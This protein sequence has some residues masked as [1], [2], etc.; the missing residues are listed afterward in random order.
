MKGPH[1]CEKETNTDHDLEALGWD[2]RSAAAFDDAGFDGSLEP[3]RVAI[4]HRRGYTVLVAG[5]EVE[6]DV[7]GKLRKAARLS[8]E[9]P[10]VGD[11]VAL[12]R[13]PGEDRAV[14]EAVLPRRSK[15][16]RKVAGFDVDEQ[17]V[18]ANV[19]LV[20]LVSALDQDLNVRRIE[21]YL[22]LTWDS[23]ARPVIVLTKADL[24]EDVPGAVAEVKAHAPDVPVHV[25][26]SVTLDG[27]D[28]LKSY[29]GQRRTIALLGSSGTGKSTLVNKLA[30]DDV[31]KVS[32]IRWDGKGRHTTTHRR[33]LPLSTGDWL[34]DTPG[35]RE[36]Q[37]WDAGEG[38]EVAF[39]DVAEL[40]AR[41]R[42]NDCAHDSE[43]GCAV[44]AALSEGTLDPAR[45]ES[46]RTQAREIASLTDR[47]ERRLAKTKGRPR[48]R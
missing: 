32:D 13:L 28:Q 26:S 27:Y 19:D 14:I 45:L 8:S 6:A 24:C 20:F 3:G 48:P 43:P 10:A 42:F 34:I 25:V 2:E 5:A 17:V 4:E 37:L 41:C 9:L 7:T 30:G 22:T 31:M 36:L 35:M 38:L 29:L 18:A 1:G 16:S 21:R 12:T 11:W 23:G 44:K 15:F 46:Y 33:L 39:A 47:L 40:A